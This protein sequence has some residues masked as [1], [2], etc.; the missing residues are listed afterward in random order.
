MHGLKERVKSVKF[1]LEPYQPFQSDTHHFSI[2]N[3]FS[4]VMQNIN[5]DS[6]AGLKIL[7]MRIG[8]QTARASIFLTIQKIKINE[9]HSIG[10]VV[11]FLL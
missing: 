7:V 8:T 11:K 1:S 3:L 9:V 6:S 4:K 2:K 5:F 10:V